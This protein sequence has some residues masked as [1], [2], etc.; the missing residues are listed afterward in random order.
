M[1][2]QA[3]VFY[4]NNGRIAGRLPIWVQETL[5]TLVRMFERVGLHMNLGKINPMTCTPGFISGQMGK[6]VY[7]RWE[8]GGG[9]TF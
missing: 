7:K 5:T 8:T 4:K 9:A 2:E 6:E 1:G 3:I